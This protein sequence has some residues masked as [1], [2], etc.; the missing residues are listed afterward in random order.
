MQNQITP[1]IVRERALAA[2]LTINKFLSGA[3]VSRST[4]WRWE[5]SGKKPHDV[6]LRKIAD[7]L[8]ALEAE[9]QA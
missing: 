6:V 5:T 2:H 7:R 9:R 4:F 1:A 3:D 8:D